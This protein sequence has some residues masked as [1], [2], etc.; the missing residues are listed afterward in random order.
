MVSMHE[1]R[2]LRGLQ[3][4]PE[5][6][7]DLELVHAVALKHTVQRLSEWLDRQADRVPATP[8]VFSQLEALADA[9]L[10]EV[11]LRHVFAPKLD[12]ILHTRYMHVGFT[13]IGGVL[14]TCVTMTL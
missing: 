3:P 8:Q 13:Y 2:A 7:E 12:W 11:G 1:Q 6:F 14:G 4:Q 9:A 10:E 5:T